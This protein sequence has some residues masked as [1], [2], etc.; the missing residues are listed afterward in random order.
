MSLELVSTDL[1]GPTSP[2]SLEGVEGA[3]HVAK[4]SDHH[5]RWREAF[6]IKNKDDT[7]TSLFHFTE[8]FAIPTDSVRSVFGRTKGG[9]YIAQH[10]K[11]YFKQT[12]I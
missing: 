2:P 9:E 6:M 5:A 3:R 4:S 7:I 10:F 8:N 11:D 12:G 1:L